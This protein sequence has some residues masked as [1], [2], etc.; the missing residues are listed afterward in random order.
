MHNSSNDSHQLF[1]RLFVFALCLIPAF[2]AGPGC[3]ET[4]NPEQNAQT[5]AQ[6]IPAP[7]KQ[8]VLLTRVESHLVCM[9]NNQFFGKQQIP[10]KVEDRIYYGCCDMCEAKIRQNSSVRLAVDPVSH[11]SVDKPLAVIGALAD[12][13]VYYFESERNMR[14]FRPPAG[15]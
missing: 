5:T 13:K 14:A 4:S 15:S 8:A 1:T 7:S 10:V 12:G 2:A 3:S 9:V 6:P 11:R